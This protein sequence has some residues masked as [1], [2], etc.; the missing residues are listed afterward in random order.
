MNDIN[1]LSLILATFIPM[2]IGFIYYQKNL[3]GRVWAKTIT[4]PKE[5]RIQHNFV[6]VFSLSFVVCFLLSLYL[7]FDCNGTGQEGSHDT[8]L[9]GMFHGLG[10]A[11]LVI[12][13]ISITGVL[14]NERSWK[15]M[16]INAGYWIIS[17]PIMGGI[18][19]AM[20]QF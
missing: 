4:M 2:V 12:I 6:G 8:F 17:L 1:W 19:D 16:L 13:P 3:F 14:Y 7:L 20:N 9:H 18:L 10:L 5:Q 11:L 15:N